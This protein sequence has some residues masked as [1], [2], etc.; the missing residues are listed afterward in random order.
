MIDSKP[1][2][3]ALFFTRSWILV[4]MSIT[5]GSDHAPLVP[6]KTLLNTSEPALRSSMNS[7]HIMFVHRDWPASENGAIPLALN[8]GIRSR[9]SPYD[10]GGFTPTWS[11]TFL[12]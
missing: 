1:V 7:S 9:M 3:N 6:A 8:L 4:S 12:L 11:K 2:M 10:W 5:A